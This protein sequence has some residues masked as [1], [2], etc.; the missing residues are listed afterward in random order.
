MATPLEGWRR[1]AQAEY[2]ASQEHTLPPQLSLQRCYYN[3][4]YYQR[5]KSVFAV[6]DMGCEQAQHTTSLW[7]WPASWPMALLP[8]FIWVHALSPW[9]MGVCVHR[10]RALQLVADVTLI[11]HAHRFPR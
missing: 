11:T 4:L 2:K 7:A 9:K 6:E 8:P 5:E 1:G 10:A 3:I